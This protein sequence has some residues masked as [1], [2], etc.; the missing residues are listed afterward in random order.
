MPFLTLL[1]TH[2]H[3]L[4]VELN[5]TKNNNDFRTLKTKDFK[6]EKGLF[7]V[8]RKNKNKVNLTVVL[9]YFWKKAE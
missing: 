9:F 4:K 1:K 3:S 2:T 6:T 8:I 5:P 7:C